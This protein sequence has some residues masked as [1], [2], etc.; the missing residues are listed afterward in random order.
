MPP[1]LLMNAFSF[2]AVSFTILLTLVTLLAGSLLLKQNVYKVSLALPI[3]F[4]FALCFAVFIFRVL[5]QKTLASDELVW[6]RQSLAVANSLT[7][8]VELLPSDLTPGKE[9]YAWLVGLIYAAAGPAPIVPIML[10]IFLF[11]LLVPILAITAGMIAESL[12]F[13]KAHGQISMKFAGYFTALVPILAFWAPRMLREI[14]SM[15]LIS[16]SVFFVLRYVRENSARF[17]LWAGLSVFLMFTIRAQIGAGLSAGLLMGVIV[18]WSMRFS[19]WFNRIFFI[20]PPF[21]L[22]FT[23]AW[24]YADS[25]RDLSVEHTAYRNSALTEANSAFSGTDELQN[26]DSILDII[27][28]NLPRVLAGPFPNEMNGSAVMILSGL[29]NLFWLWALLLACN[30]IKQR[31]ILLSMQP[32]N[33]QIKWNV[34]LLLVTLFVA[35]LFMLSIGSGNYGLV[36]R[37]RLMPFVFI[38]PLAGVGFALM[39][40]FMITTSA[41]IKEPSNSS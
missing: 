34:V 21:A 29:S 18:V 30:L 37:L 41:K 13:N 24:G 17:L 23:I 40:R 10:N 2:G 20:A 16:I 4:S 12:N 3:L 32:H 33:Q 26:A 25:T 14:I 9:G 22:L 35:F 8:G 27:L 39:K 7:Q 6:H 28:F 5:T 38:I 15:F 31:K 1:E 11:V 36:I 19:N